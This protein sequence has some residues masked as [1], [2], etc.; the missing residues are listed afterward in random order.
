MRLSE[1]IMGLLTLEHG[2]L[3]YRADFLLYACALPALAAFLL[4]TAPRADWLSASLWSVMGLVGWTLIEYTLHRFV[5]HGVHPFRGWHEA[6]HDRPRALICAPTIFSATLI[7][8]LVFLPVWAIGGLACACSVTLG[9]LVGYLAYAT[10]HHG[11]HHW[12][13]NNSWFKA[14]KRWHASHHH[15]HDLACYGVTNSFWDHVFGT[16]GRARPTVNR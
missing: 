12:R 9:L 8:V 3:A 4:W 10:T 6:H 7:A 14:R 5:L 15:A 1:D 13:A 11:T 2:K 16:A